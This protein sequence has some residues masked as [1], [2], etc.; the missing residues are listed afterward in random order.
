MTGHQPNPAMGYTIR[1][2]KTVATDLV[3]LAKAM[4]IEDVTVVDP[5]D[6]KAFRTAVVDAT[7]RDC[8]SVIIAQR[9]C[10]LLKSVKFPG[11]AAID[12]SR[13]IKCGAC[14]RLGCPSL[15]R[16]ADGAVVLD[17]TQCVGCGNCFELCPKGAIGR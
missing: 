2:E 1:N 17:A 14:L 13:C 10:A 5:F 15:S 16:S 12:D 7:E 3:L 6:M 11:P 4:G 8:P 9:P